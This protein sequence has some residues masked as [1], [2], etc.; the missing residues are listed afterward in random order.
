MGI[1][2]GSDLDNILPGSSG[3]KVASKK[4]AKDSRDASGIW[5]PSA[6]PETTKVKVT[7]T[8]K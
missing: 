2:S 7:I 8:K 5:Q 4:T 3:S 6:P 1:M